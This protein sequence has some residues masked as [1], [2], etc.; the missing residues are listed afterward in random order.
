MSIVCG[1]SELWGDSESY[2]S[3]GIA[4][5]R[6]GSAQMCRLSSQTAA[7]QEA[8]MSIKRILVPLPGSASHT[9]EIDTALS[10]AKALG[11]HVQA[12]FIS[13]PPPVTRGGVSVSE[14]AQTATA[15]SVNRHAE[16]RERT[17]RD[18]REVFAQACVPFGIPM[19]SA[20]DEPGSP[21]AASWREA[22]GS[23]VEIAV[24][25]A[26]AFDLV[27]AA[28]ATVMESLM[29]IAEQSLLQTRRP[30]L[31]APARLQ[32]DLTDSVMI[33]WDESPE[34][35]HAVSAAIPFMHLAKS[36]RVISV[37]RDA[38]NRQASQAEVLAYLR[39]HGIG[40]TAQVVTPESR[41]VGDTLLAAGAEHEA[42]LMVMGAYS[43]SRLREMLLGGATRHILK[44]ASARPVLLAH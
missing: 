13:E 26:A 39:C 32:S 42:G 16:E 38:S 36:V 12:L 18:A 7:S 3:S 14:L 4:R 43:H 41:S 17:A 15:A 9:G 25:R 22:E 2:E 21:L 44:N 37:D 28:S 8:L 27:V 29:A 19:L 31:L 30:V 34:C 6:F 24:Q 23:Y 33:A 20:N 40:A 5:C 10:A 1:S 35:W 11:A